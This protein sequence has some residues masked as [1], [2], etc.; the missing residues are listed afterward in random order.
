MSHGKYLFALLSL[1]CPGCAHIDFGGDGMTYYDPKP[2]LF[3]STTTECITTATVVTLPE[4]KKAMKLES[5]YGSAELSASLSNGMIS[6]VGQKTDTKVPE[7]IAAVGSV[8]G[9]VMSTK[10]TD[11]SK[12]LPLCKP[13][14]KMYPIKEDGKP[15]DQPLPHNF[16]AEP[17]PKEF[18]IPKQ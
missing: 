5:G 1:L 6:S 4:K 16:N 17:L 11:V 8:A 13:T 12:Q 10:S 7:T 15:E 9:A 3:V 18:S 14:A 2:Y